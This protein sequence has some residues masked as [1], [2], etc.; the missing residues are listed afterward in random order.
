[1]VPETPQWTFG[2]RAQANLGP[3]TMG[4]QAKWVDS[5]FATDVNDVIVD[6]YTVVD[7]DV[8]FDLGS[9]GLQDSYL[10]FNV[11]NLFDE[12]YFGNISTQINN[13]GGPNFSTGSPQTFM[14]TLNLAWRA[15]S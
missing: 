2:G 1:M 12:R 14:L 8:R 7:A 10:Q 4:V 5:R 13:A 3:F 11:T 9:I 6:D 15:G